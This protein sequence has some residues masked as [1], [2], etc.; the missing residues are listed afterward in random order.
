MARTR[1]D[2]LSELVRTLVSL[3]AQAARA[4]ET[5]PAPAIQPAHVFDAPP[6]PFAKEP[7]NRAEEHPGIIIEDADEPLIYI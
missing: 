7:S 1:D 3:R 5:H 4:T 2:D 6:G